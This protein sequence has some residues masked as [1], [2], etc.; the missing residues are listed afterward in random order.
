MTLLESQSNCFLY[1]YSTI[2]ECD[3]VVGNIECKSLTTTNTEALPCLLV[4]LP[5]AHAEKKSAQTTLNP[6]HLADL[7][8]QCRLPAPLKLNPTLLGALMLQWLMESLP[9]HTNTP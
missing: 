8:P 7:I 5:D 6:E 9:C 2:G 4:C 1:L 3:E